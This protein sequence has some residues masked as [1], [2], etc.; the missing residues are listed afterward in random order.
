MIFFVVGEGMAT[1]KAAV[2]CRLEW[3]EASQAYSQQPRRQSVIENLCHSRP[4]LHRLLLQTNRYLW[5]EAEL[6]RF[7][8]STVYA[9]NL[10]LVVPGDAS[11]TAQRHSSFHDGCRRLVITQQAYRA[12]SACKVYFQ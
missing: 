4:W 5:D 12:S 3:K 11:G 6:F 1:G 9:E 10:E 8:R 7:V 2:V